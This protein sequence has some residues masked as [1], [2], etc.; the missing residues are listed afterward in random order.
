MTGEDDH[1]P[2]I[3]E[4]GGLVQ[5]KRRPS[6]PASVHKQ[7][8]GLQTVSGASIPPS[9]GTPCRDLSLDRINGST[10]C[11]LDT[12]SLMKD[13][14][15]ALD[16]AEEGAAQAKLIVNLETRLGEKAQLDSVAGLGI[17]AKALHDGPPELEAAGELALLEDDQQ[18]V[19]GCVETVAG[20]WIRCVSV[21]RAARM[22][23]E[24]HDHLGIGQISGA[25]KLAAHSEHFS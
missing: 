17:G 9:Q 7:L 20:R 16:V 21:D 18:L 15:L 10:P 4:L 3:E 23:A 2:R 6:I 1:D 24:E 11:Q 19:V 25:P 13:D 12:F 22:R 5:F 8:K 14:A